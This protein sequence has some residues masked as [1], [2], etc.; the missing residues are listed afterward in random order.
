[1]QTLLGKLQAVF[2]LPRRLHAAIDNGAL[3][4]AV[5]T[6]ADAEPLLRRYGHKVRSASA[7]P[8]HRDLQLTPGDAQPHWDC[9][10]DVSLSPEEVCH[11]GYLLCRHVIL[12]P[13]PQHAWPACMTFV[14]SDADT[15]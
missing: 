10:E 2:E 5:A 14:Q 3:E 8:H 4:I 12:R 1:V 9:D 11:F 6:Y 7:T 15:A 13:S